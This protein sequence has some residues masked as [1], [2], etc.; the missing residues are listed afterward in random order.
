MGSAIMYD[1]PHLRQ[2]TSEIFVTRYS[3]R[4]LIVDQRT[5]I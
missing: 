1:D 4:V 5:D 3:T 2:V